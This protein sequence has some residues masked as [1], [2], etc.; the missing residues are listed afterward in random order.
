VLPRA[1]GD[2]AADV[3]AG[4]CSAESVADCLP[5]VELPMG[6][7]TDQPL[8]AACT[9]DSLLTDD[10]RTADPRLLVVLLEH[11]GASPPR[12]ESI[13]LTGGIATLGVA[14]DLD[15]VTVTARALG[16]HY[17]P[18]A[19][20]YRAE[21]TAARVRLVTL[22]LDPRC[23]WASFALPRATV[24][25]ADR[26]RMQV[27]V[28]GAAIDVE[29][30]V[31]ALAGEA[32]TIRTARAPRGIGS[33]DVEFAEL[34][35]QA[36]ARFGGQW[37]GEWPA[38]PYPLRYE[39]VSFVWR[40]PE[41]IF[42]R[43]RCP[44]AV[45]DVGGAACS[46]ASDGEGRCTYMCPG[47][48]TADAAGLDL[49]VGVTFT[50]QDPQQSWTDTI[51]RNGQVLTSYEPEGGTYLRANINTWSTDVPGSRIQQVAIYGEDGE[52]RSYGVTHVPNLRVP[53]RGASCEPVRFRPLGERSYDDAIATVNDGEIDFGKPERAARLASFSMLL[54][55]GAGPSWAGTDES[56]PVYFSGLGMVAVHLRP[57]KQPAAR[58]GYE[59]RVGGTLGRWGQ[60]ELDESD[61]ATSPESAER[62][63]GWARVL[64]EPGI[65]ASV[66]SRVG[67]GLGLGI[68]ASFPFRRSDEL[69]GD[70]FRLIISPSV[71]ARIRVQNWL[72]LV[73]Q[74][75][76]VFGESRVEQTEADGLKAR[77]AFYLLTML[78]FEFR[79]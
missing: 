19:R 59:I 72:W 76:P 6:V 2:E 12:I 47:A 46:A 57:R 66:T 78:G 51:A 5:R 60:V 63:L 61:P 20:S 44:S 17:M 58:I 54:A 53:I 33:I 70:Q 13:R 21:A 52:V 7:G 55:V 48:V 31:G 29:R 73:L 10:G 71:D 32:L 15:N 25:E 64:V 14:A 39:Q 23:E 30:C 56:P 22:P 77:D 75:R 36:S 69:L 74:G 1:W 68:G 27:K 40:A 26:A 35:G 79:F 18:H 65:V 67:V 24:T 4:R 49:P 28:H 16:G 34:P 43:D 38:M 62:R 3:D 45:L 11:V 42:P 8:W 50:K 9:S 37:T 41:C